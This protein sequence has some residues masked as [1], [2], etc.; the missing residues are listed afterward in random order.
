MSKHFLLELD[1]LLNSAVTMVLF[2]S[3][4]KSDTVVTRAS[5]V[6]VTLGQTI[7]VLFLLNKLNSLCDV[8]FC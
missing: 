1:K 3:P 8:H 2:C 7:S 6:L 4:W 5:G